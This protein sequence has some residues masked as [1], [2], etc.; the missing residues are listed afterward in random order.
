MK[1]RFQW[2]RTCFFKIH[3]V[4][5]G[6]NFVVPTARLLGGESLSRGE[7]GETRDGWNW[8]QSIEM[9]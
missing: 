5:S 4:P 2:L 6:S 8:I 3:F 9:T 1:R 7:R